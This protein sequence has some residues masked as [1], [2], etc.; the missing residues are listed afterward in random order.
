MTRYTILKGIKNQQERDAEAIESIIAQLESHGRA[1]TFNGQASRTLSY[2]LRKA[3]EKGQI[4]F[5]WSKP[6]PHDYRKQP[7]SIITISPEFKL[8]RTSHFSVDLSPKPIPGRK[9]RR[10]NKGVIN[11]EYIF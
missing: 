11:N 7:M 1:F 8:K 5:S 3:K 6:G 2:R 10:R 9:K 4:Y